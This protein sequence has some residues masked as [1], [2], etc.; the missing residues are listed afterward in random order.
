MLQS[1]FKCEYDR[2][3]V[4]GMSRPVLTTL[5]GQRLFSGKKNHT[6]CLKIDV[7]ITE[8]HVVLCTL[9]QYFGSLDHLDYGWTSFSS[10]SYG[11]KT[12]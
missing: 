10:H 12:L 11:I 9:I 5:V 1:D 2:G 6:K 3:V 7:A 8:V 4:L